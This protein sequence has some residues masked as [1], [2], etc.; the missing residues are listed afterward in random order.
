MV[1]VAAFEAPGGAGPPRLRYFDDICRGRPV[2]TLASSPRRGR[3]A[4]PPLLRRHLP[5]RPMTL[6]LLVRPGGAG[7]SRLRYFDDI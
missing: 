6:L 2:T 1:T 4:M 5:G 3:P 7:P